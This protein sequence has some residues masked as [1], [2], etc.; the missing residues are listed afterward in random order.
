M[1]T[2]KSLVIHNIMEEAVLR[3]VDEICDEDQARP[4]SRY[5]TT[6][7]C[8][9]DV[10]CFVLNRVPQRYV[11]S[12]RGQ[13][14][15]ELELANDQQLF[16]DLVTLTHE[17]LKRVSSVR[18]AFYGD[19]NTYVESVRGPHCYLPTIKG[20]LFDGTTFELMSEV[21]VSLLRDDD[22]VRMIDSR[23]QNPYEIVS[24]TAGTYLF[25]PAPV[26]TDADGERHTFEFEIRVEAP[27]Y[28]PFHH[29]FTVERTSIAQIPDAM[30]TSGEHRLPDLYL[31]PAS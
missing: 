27:G 13:A 11:S 28:D 4:D 21:T 22:P 5:C 26:E 2:H 3:V 10:A 7:E 20:R 6:S 1:A 23:W 17:G 12:A 18:R 30:E 8:R 19:A 24:N 31:L 25:W 9:M 16:V 14:H 15:T 29:F